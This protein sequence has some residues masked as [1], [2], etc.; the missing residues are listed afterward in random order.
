MTAVGAEVCAR[1]GVQCSVLCLAQ[2]QQ[3]V[4]PDC[5]YYCVAM[6]C[7]WSCRFC[8]QC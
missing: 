6:L 2:L 5:S 8:M 4:L 3:T 7:G 1:D